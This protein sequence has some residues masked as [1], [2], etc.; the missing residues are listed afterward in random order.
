MR[1]LIQHPKTW[2]YIKENWKRKAGEKEKENKRKNKNTAVK[3]NRKKKKKT[4]K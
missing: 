4:E 3:I 1:L 2:K